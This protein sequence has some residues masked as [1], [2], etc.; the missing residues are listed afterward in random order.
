MD[1]K[2]V[3]EVNWTVRKG[4]L[5]LRWCWKGTVRIYNMVKFDLLALSIL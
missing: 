2:P 5:W 4:E 3:L 1:E